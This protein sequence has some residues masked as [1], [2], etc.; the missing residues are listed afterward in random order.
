MTAQKI[1]T[2]NP[3][4]GAP[5]A[6][7]EAHSPEQIA[8]ILKRAAQAQK[9]W[10]ERP[11]PERARLMLRLSEALLEAKAELAG[12]METEMGKAQA[13]ALAEIEKCAGCARFY[14]EKGPSFLAPIDV[15]TEASHSFV[16]FEP[17]GV[18]LAIMPWNFPFWQVFRCAIPALLAGN[19]VVLKHASNVTGCALATERIWSGISE[20]PLFQAV[21]APGEAALALID[22]PEIAAVSFTGSTAVGKK[23]A[24]TA[25][26]RL[27]KCVLE[28]GGSDPYVVLADADIEAAAKVCANS[29]LI[30]AGQ[31]CISA[32]RFIVEASVKEAFEKKLTAALGQACLAPLAREDL[33]NDLHEQVKKSIALGAKPL[34]GGELP[35][36]PG[37]FYPATVLTGVKPGMPAFDEELFGPVAAV[38]EARDEKHAIEL[39]NQTIYGLGAAVFTRD[40]ARGEKIAKEKLDAGACFV[41]EFVRS[42]PRLPFGGTKESG[43]GRELA[44]FGIREFTNI[45]TVYVG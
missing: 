34:I 45:K 20:R 1:K 28:L 25:A 38:I 6:T 4:S 32:K 24:A 23:I 10:K 19:T 43:Y 22:R 11:L 40:K 44:D 21:L 12:L 15:E 33:R 9:E 39:A 42:D 16:S 30:N 18:V 7:Y 8:A 5:I 3:A 2:V 26:A 13:E 27:K 35:G 29:R 37:A 17:L 14:A 41:N 36:G 31:S